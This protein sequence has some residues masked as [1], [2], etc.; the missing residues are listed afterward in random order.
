MFMDEGGIGVV[1]GYRRSWRAVSLLGVQKQNTNSIG[2]PRV[3]CCQQ[4][5]SNALPRH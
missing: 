5:R 2:D 1:I 3:R 4:S